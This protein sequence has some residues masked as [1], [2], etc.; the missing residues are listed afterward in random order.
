MGRRQDFLVAKRSK[1]SIWIIFFGEAIVCHN[2]LGGMV[3]Q[4]Y[5]VTFEIRPRGKSRVGGLPSNCCLHVGKTVGTGTGTVGTRHAQPLWALALWALVLWA[6]PCTA[7]VGMPTSH[8]P[9]ILGTPNSD[10]LSKSITLGDGAS[11]LKDNT[12]FHPKLNQSI[13]ISY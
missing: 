10:H 3:C 13:V 12:G 2:H 4:V 9:G 1:C 6:L 7:T 5:F 11:M 8:P